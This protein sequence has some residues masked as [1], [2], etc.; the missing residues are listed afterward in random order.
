MKQTKMR[1]FVLALALWGLSSCSQDA[2]D[3]QGSATGGETVTFRLDVEVSVDDEQARLIDHKLGRNAQG[4]LVPMP[5]FA[6]KEEVKVHTILK[7]ST[8]IVAVKTLKWRYDAAKKKLVLKQTDGHDIEVSGFNNDNGTKWY[9]SGLIDDASL[10]VSGTKVGF[11]GTR[12]LKGVDGNV[13]D[14]LGS[15]AVP[16]AFGWTELTINTSSPKDNQ[17]SYKYAEVPASKN[18]K[19]QPL[20]SLIAVKI[21]TN[22]SAGDYTFTPKGFHLYSNAWSDYGSFELNTPIPASEP[23][24]ALPTWEDE[25]CGDGVYYTFASGEEPGTIAH[26]QTA[27]KTYYVWVMP[28]RR[29]S[30]AS[31]NVRVM[32]TG[33]SSRPQTATYRDYTNVWFTDYRVKISSR[34]KVTPG[35]VHALT[36]K[37]TQRLALPIEYV[38]EYNLAGGE[39]L[40]YAVTPDGLRPDGVGPLRFATSHSNDQ[41]GYYNWYKVVGR[42]NA[43]YNPDTRNLQTE[44]D[45]TFGADKYFIP[46]I[47]QWWGV[48]PSVPNVVRDW[49]GVTT[50][51][52]NIR[53]FMAVGFGRDLLRQS[54]YSDYSQSFTLPH[55]GSD[56]TDDAVFYA[57]RFKAHTNVCSPGRYVVELDATTNLQRINSYP[58]ARDN[59]L[60]CAYRFRRVGG[61]SA[62]ATDNGNL[63]NRVIIDVVYLGEEDSPTELSTISDESWWASKSAQGLVISRSFPAAGQVYEPNPSSAVSGRRHFFGL[64][65]PHWSTSHSDERFGSAVETYSQRV[66]GSAGIFQERALAVRLFV[67]Q[68]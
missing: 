40:T 19:F 29:V 65:A 41:S 52:S 53:E 49:A 51:R 10:F 48:Y 28:R 1:L 2:S 66:T 20:G 14:A 44:V 15:I 23:E 55:G 32:L 24:K 56:D 43:Q 25:P 7:S 45:K 38:A 27:A 59:L 16:Y 67:R 46:T 68:N 18:V 22:Q 47:E 6:D 33:T 36:V 60:K 35:R 37:A 39:G 54:Y 3:V 57:I 4:Q 9:I 58:P 12:V 61:R 50:S 13:G 63:S 30:A 31:A 17:A 26:N 62:W 8:G 34:G 64:S 11:M 42:H 5:Q 21:G